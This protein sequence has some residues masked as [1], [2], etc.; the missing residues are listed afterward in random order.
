MY[1]KPRISPP[2]DGFITQ[3]QVLRR[4]PTRLAPSASTQ[5]PKRK[6]TRIVETDRRARCRPK[7]H[8]CRRLVPTSQTDP[9]AVAG[10]AGGANVGGRYPL[11]MRLAVGL[12]ALVVLTCLPD[13]AGGAV[14]NSGIAGRVVAGPTCPVE[15][16]PPQPRCAP[17]PLMASMRIRRVG[18][19]SLRVVRSGAD[20]R[21]RDWLAPATYVV[22]PLP[23]NGSL[24]RPPA[25]IQVQVRAGRF[26]NITITYDT[27]IR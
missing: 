17:R 5:C 10:I 4:A 2:H 18:H 24:P 27:G 11:C 12:V 3:N 7:W 14:A 6:P 26:T 23:V 9:D 21:F 22:Q 20:G 19:L 25:P 8:F 1:V 16:V 13:G 15:T